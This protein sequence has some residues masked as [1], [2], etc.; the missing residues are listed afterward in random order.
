[1]YPETSNKDKG[2]VQFDQET[3]LN[4]PAKDYDRQRLGFLRMPN[5]LSCCDTFSLRHGLVLSDISIDKRLLSWRICVAPPIMRGIQ[6][7]LN[8]EIDGPDG[9]E[10]MIGEEYVSKVKHVLR[11]LLRGA[12]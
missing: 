4:E 1:L 3:D 7:P 10:D 12:K 11:V 9:V 2:R 6:P 5:P 8:G